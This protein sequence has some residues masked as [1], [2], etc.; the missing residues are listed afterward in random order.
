TAILT[1]GEG[2]HNYHHAFDGDYRY[3]IRWFDLDPSKWFIAGLAKIVW[4]YDLKTTPKHLIEI[5]KAKVKLEEALTK[6]NKT[7]HL[8]IAEKYA[9]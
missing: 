8:G 2:Y 1:G 5:D 3:G 4:C 7:F 9:K 6:K